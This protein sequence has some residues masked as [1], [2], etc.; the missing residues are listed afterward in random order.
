MDLNLKTPQEF[1]D[2][3][4]EQ[5]Q[6]Q[7]ALKNIQISKV[8]FIG[9][10]LNLMGSMQFDIK[11][12][13]DALFKE[14][15]PITVQDRQNLY[16]HS[17]LYGYIPPVASASHLVGNFRFN[18]NALPFKDTDVVKRDI[19]LTGITLDLTTDTLHYELLSNYHIINQS[20]YFVAQIVDKD[21]NSINLNFTYANPIVPLYNFEQVEINTTK[22][23]LPNYQL[24]SYYAKSIN[25]PYDY[26]NDIE[27]YVN[28][29]R[30]ETSYVKNFASGDDKV[31]FLRHLSKTLVIEFGS[32][33]HGKYIP[34][35]NVE[36]IVYTTKGESGNI[37]ENH[38]YKPSNGEITVIDTLAD[39]TTTTPYTFPAINFITID[40][41]YGEG[42]RDIV[43]M[44]TLRNNLI[45]YIRHNDSLVS[46][47]DFY[48]K[49]AESVFDFELLFKKL[50]VVDNNIYMHIPFRDQYMVPF[51]TGNYTVYQSDFDTSSYI[52]YNGDNYMYNLYPEFVHDDTTSVSPFL[53]LKDPLLNTWKGYVFYQEFN[54]YFDNFRAY[55]SDVTVIPA[56]LQ[57]EFVE[58][59][60]KF[61]FKSFQNLS[62]FNF[63][64]TCSQLHISNITMTLE[65][66][67]TAVVILPFFI[68]KLDIQVDVYNS[69]NIKILTYET[70]QVT[71]ILDYSNYNIL[72][73]Y[74]PID[75]TSYYTLPIPQCYEDNCPSLPSDSVIQ[76]GIST[77]CSYL[78]QIPIIEK[79]QFINNQNYIMNNMVSVFNNVLNPG[80]E[81]ISDEVMIKF[82]Q[83]EY[84][85]SHILSLI[86]KQSYNFDL[87]LPL[88]LTVDIYQNIDYVVNNNID[89]QSELDLL[90]LELA[91]ILNTKYTGTQ[92]S[93][94]RTQIVDLVHN[95]EWVKHV[96]VFVYDKNAIQIPYADIETI[97]NRDVLDIIPDKFDAVKFEPIYWWWDINNIKLNLY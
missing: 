14:A 34:N 33:T 63:R 28:D 10:I 70:A 38:T 7:L 80:N 31:V 58:D 4:W 87:H 51:Y 1:V 13:Y 89:I 40:V 6:E 88:Y 85:P 47:R 57:F 52:E 91:D 84:V 37:G 67:N 59:H 79:Q 20:D 39:G 72:K 96:N 25:I 17:A 76:V 66:D 36:V 5:I 54:Q 95:R 16:F 50:Q 93:F 71:P 97:S 64:F 3:Y 49:F 74:Q 2:Y 21:N 41:L 62:Q 27:V 42:G 12:Y 60:F 73:K 46:E 48:D 43:D 86:T 11:Q 82:L 22:F 77:E 69:D 61:K 23:V 68:D 83:T 19:Y 35:H 30:Y 15:F 65:D 81:M 8:G 56:S 18:I 75:S 53:Y 78:I 29:E 45:N 55:F 26:I 90:N 9:F 94:Y 92:I 32:G 44:N 24:G